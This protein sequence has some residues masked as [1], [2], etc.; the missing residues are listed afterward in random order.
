MLNKISDKNENTLSS[1]FKAT[2][3]KG[4]TITYGMR[5]MYAEEIE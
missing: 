5:F 4:Y 2:A 1:W 3:S